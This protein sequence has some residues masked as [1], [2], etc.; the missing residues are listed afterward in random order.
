MYSFPGGRDGTLHPE[1]RTPRPRGIEFRP[2]RAHPSTPVSGRNLPHP[3]TRTPDSNH[4]RAT[5]VHPEIYPTCHRTPHRPS[6][7]C[8][9][10]SCVMYEAESGILA[11]GGSLSGWRF[12]RG[13][14]RVASALGGEDVLVLGGLGGSGS[15]M[16]VALLGWLVV[17]GRVAGRP[18][19]TARY[20][21]SARRGVHRG[22]LAQFI[23][24]IWRNTSPK[25][26][27]P[28][29]MLTPSPNPRIRGSEPEHQHKRAP[30]EPTALAASPGPDA[31]SCAS[32]AYPGHFAC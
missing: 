6:R 26:S 19:S 2:S 27:V 16:G 5:P 32:L 23:I 24:H 17:M 13:L 8:F 9:S 14:R 30:G 22:D 29:W 15:W 28:P 4:A 31:S 1:I 7:T 18:W 12:G 21:G 10:A 3:C 25:S 20:G 11:S